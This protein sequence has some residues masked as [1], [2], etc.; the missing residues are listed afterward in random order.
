VVVVLTYSLRRQL[1][2]G[3][4]P[5][6]SRSAYRGRETV[7][8]FVR[9]L[10]CP[11][12]S[13]VVACGGLAD[14]RSEA[15][16]GPSPAASETGGTQTGGSS[17][18]GA[19]A[20]AG[21]ATGGIRPAL[22]PSDGGTGGSR[23]VAWDDAATEGCPPI[24]TNKL[25]PIPHLFAFG[26]D[27]GPCR[28][29]SDPNS[30]DEGMTYEYD[31]LGRPVGRHD[32]SGAGRQDYVYEGD[33]MVQIVDQQGPDWSLSYEPR[34]FTWTEAGLPRGY[35]PLFIDQRMRVVVELDSRGYPR[36]FTQSRIVDG[37][38]YYEHLYR[39]AGCRIVREESSPTR[40]YSYDSEGHLISIVTD[41]GTL[42]V[43]DYSCWME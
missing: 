7:T 25:A 5:T 9:N 31:T 1:G 24:P 28:V 33:L 12:L 26:P 22:P 19:P 13:F 30:F 23:A 20:S 40:T 17:S 32:N 41:S 6:S 2:A 10:A 8:V 38:V 21:S 14:H 27:P 37:F 29:S 11:S 15:T 3:A 4:G 35:L 34:A 39:Y 43:Y 16:T 36:R 42:E 18:G